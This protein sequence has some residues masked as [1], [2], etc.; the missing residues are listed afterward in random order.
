MDDTEH[1]ERLVVALRGCRQLGALIERLLEVGRVAT[2]HLELE[3]TDVD[4][5]ALV[6]DV[7]ERFEAQFTAA[8][9]AVDVRFAESSATGFWDKLR[10]E[11]V[12]ANL[13]TNAIK[14]GA[15]KPIE[16]VCAVDSGTAHVRIQDR[17]IGIAAGDQERIFKRFERGVPP[18]HYGGLGLGL[19]ISREIV[20]RHGGTLRVESHSGEG[21]SFMIDLPRAQAAEVS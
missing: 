16:I 19:W 10:L 18:G 5:N 1:R 9:C 6:R 2:G 3:R 11:Q 14:F 7:A 17:G 15:G 4:L 8:G 13:L 21:A 12:L 20:E